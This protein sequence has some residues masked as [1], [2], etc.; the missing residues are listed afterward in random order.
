MDLFGDWRGRMWG[1]V[2]GQGA[3]HVVQ[4]R[5]KVLAWESR[6]AGEA[7]RVRWAFGQMLRWWR[8]EAGAHQGHPV[9]LSKAP[10]DLH[11][12]AP[13][14]NS[15]MGLHQLIFQTRSGLFWS[16]PWDFSAETSGS[17]SRRNLRS[18]SKWM[19]LLNI[20]SFI[21]VTELPRD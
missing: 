6:G 10:R 18:G 9:V 8:G 3:Y 21:I 11:S 13:L 2:R 7:V 1:Q 16:Q 20:I 5:G 17:G 12:N 15:F 19:A 14:K 4:V